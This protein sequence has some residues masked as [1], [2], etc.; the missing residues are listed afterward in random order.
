MAVYKAYNRLGR[1]NRGQCERCSGSRQ[2]RQHLL[3]GHRAEN[4]GRAGNHGATLEQRQDLFGAQEGLCPI[5]DKEVDLRDSI[6]H[7]HATGEVRAILHGNCNRLVGFAEAVG[8]RASRDFASTSG[9]R[10]SP[11]GPTIGKWRPGRIVSQGGDLVSD[12]LI[13]PQ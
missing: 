7:D 12:L 13:A 8:P 6:D 9:R 4:S 2:P 10:P 11:T 3:R 5:C 1:R